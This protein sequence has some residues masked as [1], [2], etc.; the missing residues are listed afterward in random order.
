MPPKTPSPVLTD[1][2]GVALP[3]ALELFCG[4][5]GFA[6][7][8]A[9]AAQIV[10]AIDNSDIV[11]QAYRRNF[12][13]PAHQRNL[14]TL[15][16]RRLAK[17]K[18]EF[19]WMSPPCQPYTSRGDQRDLEDTRARSLIHLMRNLETIAPTRLGM[20]NVP[21]FV[22]SQAHELVIETLER[23][24]YAWRER[25]LC[26][27]QL[28]VPMR[29]ERYYLVASRDGLGDDA[30]LTVTPRTLAQYVDLAADAD[31]DLRIAP[32]HVERYG[33]G[34][35]LL[36]RDDPEAVAN[37]FTA[38]YGKT[39]VA[40][41][42]YLSCPDGGVRRFSSREIARLMGFPDTFEL[43]EG[44]KLRKQWKAVGNSLSIDA[45]RAILK[46]VLDV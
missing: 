20:E 15:D 44:W 43:P 22:G 40:A 4:I 41:G 34:M 42:A 2:A 5:G 17:H 7:A 11:L 19:L 12:D 3:R 27:S 45:M 36:D 31:A 14:D 39:F 25:V 8:S 21:G 46:P 9:G 30:P 38:A 32:E 13:H 35:R 1:A 24:G 6:V 18:A 10:E 26:P 23:L 33:P 37:C 29:R 28:G 16:P